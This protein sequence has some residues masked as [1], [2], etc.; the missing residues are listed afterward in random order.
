MYSPELTYNLV[1]N[2]WGRVT[3][4]KI[5]DFAPSVMR[6]PL[7]MHPLL[8]AEKFSPLPI[9][10]QNGRGAPSATTVKKSRIRE[11]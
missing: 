4:G 9:S 1:S 7:K 3:C 2:Y 5:D 6:N 11:V 8:Q 10:V